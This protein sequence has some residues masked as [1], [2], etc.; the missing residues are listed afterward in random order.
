[1]STLVDRLLPEALWQRIQPLL[2]PPPARPH[3][4][5][6]TPRPGPQLRRRA[7]LHGRPS[8]PWS[9][10]P[11]KEL[12]CGSATTCWRR[13]DEW[14]RAGVFEQL[15]AVLLD[16]LGAAGRIDLGRVSVDSFSLRVV[17]GD[18]TG[19]NPVDR[20]KASSKLHLAGDATGLPLSL[21]VSAANASDAT[22]L[23]AVL[24]DIPAILMPTGH[25]RRR[26]GK[27][28]ADK[29]YDH[30]RCQ[31]IAGMFACFRVGVA[32]QRFRIPVENRPAQPFHHDC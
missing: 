8:T 31:P 1:M 19:A 20:G 18:L 2:P 3:G 4:G 5:G 30:R 26:S 24:D 27:V 22:V 15:Q 17:K 16:E 7:H 9:L 12:G 21:I 23:E 32:V 29:A 6:P 14:A 13:L 25:R 11:A 10:L 28:H